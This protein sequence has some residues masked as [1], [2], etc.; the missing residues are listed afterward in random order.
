MN[1]FPIYKG[2]KNASD[3][4]MLNASL[5]GTLACYFIYVTVGVLGYLTYGDLLGKAESNYL[6]VLKYSNP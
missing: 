5:I 6:L 4:K 1:F 3:K 2:M